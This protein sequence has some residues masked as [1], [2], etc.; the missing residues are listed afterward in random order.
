[1][2]YFFWLVIT[3]VI[4]GYQRQEQKTKDHLSSAFHSLPACN[5]LSTANEN[6]TRDFPQHQRLLTPPP[7]TPGHFVI[8]IRRNGQDF[9]KLEG[10]NIPKG[11][12]V[13]VQSKDKI[14]LILKS[15]GGDPVS[16]DIFGEGNGDYPLTN[17]TATGEKLKTGF[18][19]FQLMPTSAAAKKEFKGLF[20]LTAG[21][22]HIVNGGWACSGS[23]QGT[24][25]GDVEYEV[26]GLFSTVPFM[27]HK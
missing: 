20:M 25:K 22:L 5:K 8:T 11:T 21:T 10:N 27:Y 15:P 13:A 17:V 18:A 3:G 9:L 16:L 2:N 14:L 26:E 19:I 7:D 4:F 12:I 24:Y 6:L 1:M 23:F